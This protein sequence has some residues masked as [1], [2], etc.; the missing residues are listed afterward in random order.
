MLHRGGW[1]QQK[2]DVVPIRGD[3]YYHWAVIWLDAM[4]LTVM[5]FLVCQAISHAYDEIRKGLWKWW[6]TDVF[7]WIDFVTFLGGIC[8]VIFFSE[9]AAQLSLFVDF[10]ASLP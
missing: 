1:I 5:F 4:S 10:A 9:I 8:V 2:I 6:I 3:V 7:V